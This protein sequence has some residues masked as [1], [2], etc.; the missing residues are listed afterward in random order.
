MLRQAQHEAI[1][2]PPGAKPLAHDYFKRWGAYT[3]LM[4]EKDWRNPQRRINDL[5]F[6]CLLVLHYYEEQAACR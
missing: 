2:P 3:D 5:T 4:L 1:E 6:R